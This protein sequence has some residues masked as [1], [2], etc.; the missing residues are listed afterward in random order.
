MPAPPNPNW[1]TI[2]L[3]TKVQLKFSHFFKSENNMIEPTCELMH[4][5][6]QAGIVIKKL[7][8][9]NAGENIALE[10]R[11]KS[12]SWKN[13]VEVE[14]TARDTPQQN[15]VAEV[16]FYALANKA[17]AAIHQANIPMEM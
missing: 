11:L 14:Y 6:G 12:K 15:S 7:Q 16:A 10:K 4:R 13:P 3:G 9:D 2:V 8:M 5:W 17:R 1:R